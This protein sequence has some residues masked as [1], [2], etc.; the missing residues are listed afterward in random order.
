MFSA[1]SY[2]KYA[3]LSYGTLFCLRKS[4]FKVAFPVNLLLIQ[5][6]LPIPVNFLD[7]V[8]A[9]PELFPKD[10]T[11]RHRAVC[12]TIFGVLVQGESVLVR[13]RP[14]QK[15]NHDV[16]QFGVPSAPPG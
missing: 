15:A 10:A 14:H 13:D 3:A 9:E 12:V 11:G 1:V 8:R 16:A 4:L 6:L 2:P 5:S 7:V